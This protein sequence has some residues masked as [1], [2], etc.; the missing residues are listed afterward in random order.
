LTL[1]ASLILMMELQFSRRWDDSFY[2]GGIFIGLSG[3]LA[4]VIGD[5]KAESDNDE[6]E[7][8]NNN[9]EE[10]DERVKIAPRK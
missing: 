2:A 10:T 5:V 6:D 7:L 1:S 4:Y 3:V 9:N 8:N